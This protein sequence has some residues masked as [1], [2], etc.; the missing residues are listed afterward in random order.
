MMLK[1]A[2]E[3]RYGKPVRQYAIFVN[4]T[5][6]LV[7]SGDVVDADTYNAL[8]AAKVIRSQALAPSSPRPT[9]AGL[10]PEFDPPEE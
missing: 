9:M 4:G 2:R 7:T 8:I 1:G 10:N 6:T 3:T 5:I